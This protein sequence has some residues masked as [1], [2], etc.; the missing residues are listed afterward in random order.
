MRHRSIGFLNYAPLVYRIN[1]KGDLLWYKGF[2]N[3][4]IID[5]ARIG[6]FFD[7][8]ELEDGSL[9]LV[10][11][12]Y[13][14]V[15][16]DPVLGEPTLSPDILI[17]KM[18][19]DG[20]ISGYDCESLVYKVGEATQFATG[21]TNETVTENTEIKIYPNPSKG[22]FTLDIRGIIGPVDI[23]IYDIMGRDVYVHHGAHDGETTLDLHDLPR[24]LYVYKI[25]SDRQEISSG[26][27]VRE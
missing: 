20:C 23:H 3:S 6:Q 26:K 2:Y 10:G 12:I 18:T 13:S 9:M 1:N 22:K 16:Y 27:W 19:G 5:E 14:D 4:G 25:Y 24:G 11:D 7:V 17:V 8:E 15:L 21:T